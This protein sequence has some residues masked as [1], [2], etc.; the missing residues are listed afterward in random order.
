MK[1]DSIL[2]EDLL[3][4]RETVSEQKLRE[5]EWFLCVSCGKDLFFHARKKSIIGQSVALH[6]HRPLSFIQGI[7]V[8]FSFRLHFLSSLCSSYPTWQNKADFLLCLTALC[9]VSP[10]IDR[11][12]QSLWRE[13]SCVPCARSQ[14]L[15]I[16]S[17]C[18]EGSS[19][20]WLVAQTWDKC[21]Q[22]RQ[23]L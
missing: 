14:P 1:Y 18:E 6:Y 7:W 19:A 23:K 3:L 12:S 20:V 8:F 9:H 11:I 17:L 5:W 22:W 2:E 16:L 10:G 21:I 4:G 13:S 15:L